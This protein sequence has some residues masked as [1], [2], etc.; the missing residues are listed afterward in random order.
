VI[1]MIS[2]STL[3]PPTEMLEIRLASVIHSPRKSQPKGM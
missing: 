2:P 1:I 3:T